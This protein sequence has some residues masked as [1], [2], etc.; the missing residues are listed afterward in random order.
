MSRDPVYG[1]GQWA[2]SYALD[3]FDIQGQIT[4]LHQPHFTCDPENLDKQ[5]C[6]GLQMDLAAGK[7]TDTAIRVHDVAETAQAL[8]SFAAVG[9]F[10][11]QP[12]QLD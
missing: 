11:G 2:I 9:G 8:K 12:L 3:L 10:D 6:Q 7:D 4:E 1:V 5:I